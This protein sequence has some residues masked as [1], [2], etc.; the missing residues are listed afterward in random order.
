[1]TTD[2]RITLTLEI[3]GEPELTTTVSMYETDRYSREE[4]LGFVSTRIRQEMLLKIKNR[5]EA[6]IS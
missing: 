2:K 6:V 3:D 4:L 5:S 1:M